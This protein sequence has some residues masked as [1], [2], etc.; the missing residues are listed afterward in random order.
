[1]LKQILSNQGSAVGGSLVA[2]LPEGVEFPLMNLQHMQE[3]ERLL[4]GRD[5]E[6]NV[7]C[8]LYIS[9]SHCHACLK[10]THISAHSLLYNLMMLFSLLF[11]TYCALP[12]F[13]DIHIF[14]NGINLYACKT[15]AQGCETV[16]CM[17]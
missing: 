4:C 7:V 15:N 3:V 16:T 9:C 13:V 2:E 17:S 1:M 14:R 12:E 8:I 11:E 10:Q 6:K 5:I